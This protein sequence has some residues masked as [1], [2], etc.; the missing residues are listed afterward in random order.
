MKL[1]RVILLAHTNYET[2]GMYI[3]F[4]MALHY[5]IAQNRTKRSLQNA[6]GS[7]SYKP[8]EW[9]NKQDKK[10]NNI[11]LYV[12]NRWNHC[13][14]WGTIEARASRACRYSCTVPLT[15]NL[16]VLSGKETAPLDDPHV[17]N[18]LYFFIEIKKRNGRPTRS[19][20]H[21]DLGLD[22]V[23]KAEQSPVVEWR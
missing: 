1:V 23:A 16:F 6:W 8:V 20:G 5:S 15:L 18:T 7:A 12:I 13:H 3:S 11:N 10:Q 9:W 2:L 4:R 17:P 19:T 21:A 14:P 22:G